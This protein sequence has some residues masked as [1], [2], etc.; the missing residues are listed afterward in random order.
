MLP[1]APLIV[2]EGIVAVLFQ[3]A[4]SRA[5]RARPGR[6]A[7]YAIGLIG[8]V[9]VKIPAPGFYAQKD[10]HPVKIAV[11][12][13]IATMATWSSCHCLCT[14]GSLC[15]LLGSAPTRSRVPG[16]RGAAHSP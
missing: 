3:G 13:L 15:R 2:T 6:V 10:G 11:T 7:G 16:L 12:V 14:R 4:N 8:L 5:R 1:A 9:A